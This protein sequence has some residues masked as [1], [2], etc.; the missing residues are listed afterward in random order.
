MFY[1]KNY[2]IPVLLTFCT[3]PKIILINLVQIFVIEAGLYIFKCIYNYLYLTLS[4]D[5][6][7]VTC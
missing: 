2:V 1:I 4:M 7:Y 6:I 3:V 5:I